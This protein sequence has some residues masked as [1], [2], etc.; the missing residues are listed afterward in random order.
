[1]ETEDSTFLA[2]IKLKVKL[3]LCFQQSTTP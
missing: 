1:M 3:S 2:I